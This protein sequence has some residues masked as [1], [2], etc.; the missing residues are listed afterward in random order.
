MTRH[1]PSARVGSTDEK[2][3]WL[4]WKRRATQWEQGGV[5]DLLVKQNIPPL[6]QVS[7]D[8]LFWGLFI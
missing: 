4:Y 7:M 5:C 3:F 8:E 1:E 6:V 2:K